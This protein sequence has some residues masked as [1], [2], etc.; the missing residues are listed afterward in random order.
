VQEAIQS[1]RKAPPS[2]LKLRYLV[3]EVIQTSAMDCGPAALISLLEGCGIRVSYGRLREACQ[4]EVDGSSIDTLEEVANQLGLEAEQIMI[5]ADHLWLP[6]S[7]ALPAIAVVELPG[8]LTHFIVIWRR[9]GNFV[10]I[11]DP[12][13][14]R[15]WVSLKQLQQELYLHTMPVPAVAWREWAASP[16]VLDAFR[17]RLTDLKIARPKIQ[18]LL[19]MALADTSWQGLGTLD[20]AT[21]LVA[22]LVTSGGIEDGVVAGNLVESL[23]RQTY[24]QLASGETD[25]PV[26]RAYWSVR[27]LPAPQQ[28]P[29]EALYPE[30]ENQPDQETAESDSPGDAGLEEESC[31]E[32][33]SEILFRGILLVRIRRRKVLADAAT[34]EAGSREEEGTENEIPPAALSPE[35][36]A[37]LREKPTHPLNEFL[38][39]LRQDGLFDPFLIL[40]ALLVAAAGVTFE[41]LLF[42][43][44][45]NVADFLKVRE[46]QLAG[47]VALLVFFGVLIT[48]ELFVALGVRRLGR[49]LEIRLRILFLEKIPRLN[50]RYFRSRLTADMA[51]RSHSIHLVRELPELVRSLVGQTAQVVMNTVGVIWLYPA[52]MPFAIGLLLTALGVP[53]LLQPLSTQRNLRQRTHQ[54]ALARFYLDALLGQSA[55]RAHG[56]EAAMRREHESRLVEWARASLALLR[57]QLPVAAIQVFL[58]LVI[59]LFLLIAYVQSF[60]SSILENSGSILLLVYWTSAFYPLGRSIAE[61][62]QKYPTQRNVLLRLLEPIGAANEADP[63][64]NDFSTANPALL[65]AGSEIEPA[66]QAR[67]VLIEMQ[68]VSV[69]ASGHTILEDISLNIAPGSHLAI[70]GPS[71]AGKSSLVGLLLGWHR[72]ATGRVLVDGA[73][74]LAGAHLVHLRRQTAWVDPTIQLWNRSLLDNLCYGATNGPAETS[75]GVAGQLSTIIEQAEL[76]ALLQNLPAGL[77]TVLGENGALVSGGEGQRVRLGRAMTRRDA[78]LVI[79]DEPFRGLTAQQRHQLLQSARRLWR[80]ATLLCIT[81]DVSETLAFDRVLVVEDGKIKEDDCPANL[82]R[83]SGSRYSQMFQAEQL[84]HKQ[85]WGSERW[86]KIRLENGQLEEVVREEDPQSFLNYLEKP[87]ATEDFSELASAL[88]FSIDHPGRQFRGSHDDR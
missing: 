72:P 6:E 10:Q 62:L 82:L 9:A 29:A 78:R 7:Q 68:E 58:S 42:R 21:R 8:K 27:A 79:L 34:P 55:I 24:A 67:G 61:T 5:P 64:P 37:A 16:E 59:H 15:R 32:P 52:G 49:R 45:L 81:H 77:Q 33:A 56:A 41:G 46:Q 54:G 74:E 30:Q 44:L 57:V 14:G 26:A 36:A 73:H 86:R 25:L 22:A 28:A 70:V 63:A 20:A 43:S 39:V 31:E 35:L 1:A 65:D 4:T 18:E 13:T 48:L 40:V 87:A 11:M 80:D 85:L 60:G 69:Q 17:R 88:V 75:T 12:A 50:D 76:I 38:K 71:G 47:L 84:V 83:Q 51:E 19:A 2:K 66:S 53:L 3:P 23:Y